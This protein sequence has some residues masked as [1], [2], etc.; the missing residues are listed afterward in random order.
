MYLP[1]KEGSNL[2]NVLRGFFK[3]K[4]LFLGK[5]SFYKT[6]SN[7][8]NNIEDYFLPFYNEANNFIV[9]HTIF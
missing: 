9:K 8:F 6:N 4:N 1:F 7:F 2:L 3:K 5:L